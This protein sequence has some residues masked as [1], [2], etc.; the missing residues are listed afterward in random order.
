LRELGR[1]EQSFWNISTPGNSRYL[2]FLSTAEIAEAIGASDDDVESAREWLVGIGAKRSS[3]RVSSLRDTI[4]ATFADAERRNLREVSIEK[5]SAVNFVV[6]RQAASPESLAALDSARSGRN[7]F[8]S[9]YT[10][11]NIK[12]AYGVPTDLKASNESTLQMVWGPGTFGYSQEELSDF[13][14]SQCPLL[15]M[16]KVKFDTENH[17]QE[18]GDNFGEGNL[19]TQMI[20]AFG[21]NVMTLVSNT[22]TSSST[23]EGEGFGQALLDFVTELASRNDV[24]HVLSMSLGS[25]TAYSC[26]LLC[27]EAAKAGHSLEECND[28]L[29]QQRQ[30]C[31]FLSQDQVA[32]ISTA[33]QVLGARGVSV[34]MASGD[35]GSHF[36]FG[37]FPEWSSIGSTLNKVSCEYQM[38]VAPTNSPYIVGVGGESWSGGSSSHPITWSGS[39]GGFSWQFDQ[40]EHQ[41]AAASA[42]LTKSGMPPASSFNAHGAVYPDMAAI[43]HMGTS[44]A[45]PIA[46]GIFSMII[47]QRLNLG[48]PP[49]GFVGPRIWQ[50]AKNFPG[51]AFFDITEGNSQ[52]TCDNGF[53]ATEGWDPNTGHGR[54]IWSGMLK[55]F[56]SD[57]LDILV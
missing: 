35:G 9:S 2:K 45:A 41:K 52:T 39:G 57:D 19:D 56:G 7:T 29:Q 20:T 43:G 18:G 30:V 16:D 32:R 14:S 48:L 12:N 17:G 36:S 42:Y 37:E 8:Q 24:P 40:P 46:A 15:N 6:R 21:L 51:E 25:L 5:P 23:E 44:Q 1:F 54:P 4:T 11:S 3:L 50:V 27:S 33:F 49:L 47:D 38:P 13:Q 53:P 28:F 10:I 34:F 55:H 26:D 31:M 22:N